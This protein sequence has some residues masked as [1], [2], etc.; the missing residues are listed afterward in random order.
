M[1]ERALHCKNCGFLLPCPSWGFFYVI[2]N[3]GNKLVLERQCESAIIAE[4]LGI[5]EDDI[6]ER[7]FSPEHSEASVQ[8][9]QER[10]GYK[11]FSLCRTCLGQSA[12]DKARDIVK[13]PSCGSHDVRT[14]IQL[15]G[16][17]CPNCGK[18][19]IYETE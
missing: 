16:S 14:L 8:L 7:G 18:G 19:T 10:V 9:M 17:T 6:S 15:I 13:C 4:A 1:S 11:T 5:N 3:D 12:F 2:D